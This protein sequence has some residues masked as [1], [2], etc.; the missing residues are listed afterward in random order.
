LGKD[1]TKETPN[2]DARRQPKRRAS[3]FVRNT[4]QNVSA[5]FGVAVR[6]R[7]K[8]Q[9]M[10]QVELANAAGISRSYLSEVERGQ[11][12]ISL[13]RADRIAKVLNCDLADLLKGD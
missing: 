11:E 6:Q 13:E 12:S 5:R 1:K 8:E 9:K 4:R 3:S 10:T 2:K 7:R